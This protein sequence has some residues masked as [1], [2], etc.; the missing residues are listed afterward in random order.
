[1]TGLNL[2]FDCEL[3]WGDLERCAHSDSY[4]TAVLRGREA[5]GEVIDLLG[6][7]GLRSTW[8]VTA[9]IACS[10]LADVER[11]APQS[12][13]AIG[14]AVVRA[15]G[16]RADRE[17]LLFDQDMIRLLAEAPGVEIG[18]HGFTHLEATKY[19]AAVLRADLAASVRVLERFSRNPVESF[20]PP[21]NCL[22]TAESL[23]GTGIRNVRHVPT[24]LGS[25]YGS[26][27][28]W[29]RGARLFND[30]VQPATSLGSDGQPCWLVFLRLDRGKLVFRQQ[31]GMIRRIAGRKRGTLYC[32]LHPHNVATPTARR[33]LET[34][35][36]VL[37]D[38]FPADSDRSAVFARRVG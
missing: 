19:P 27:G 2:S 4:A 28:G 13:A 38:C 14:D 30:L 17:R 36:M 18:S 3:A 35:M 34:I 22:W 23:L 11:E 25:H 31:V 32:Y 37:S 33:R 15:L 29:A 7:Y 6:R 9:A 12:Y 26:D 10:S 1:M 8:G 24:V 21:R 20:I 16:G 5:T